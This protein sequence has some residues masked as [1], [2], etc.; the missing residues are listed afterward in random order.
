MKRWLA[1]APLAV[2]A[3][4]A[5]LFAGY[6]L[7]HD[8]HVNP[9]ALVGKP[10]PALTLPALDGGPAVAL[11]GPRPAPVLI[12]FFASWCAPCARSTRA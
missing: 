12:N 6:A 8:P 9:A 7:N 10:V 11:G 1:L 5:A 2:L 3:A 4:L